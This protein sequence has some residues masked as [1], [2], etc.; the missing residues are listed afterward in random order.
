MDIQISSNFERL[1]FELGGRD[2]DRVR[3]LMAGLAQ[4]GAFTLAAGEHA[5]LARMFAAHRVGEDEALAAIRR[6]HA[7]TGYVSEPHTIA[8]IEAARRERASGAARGVPVITLATA[9]PAKFPAA[10]RQAL[11]VAP[12]EPSRVAEQRTKPERISVLPND[13]RAIAE[14]VSNRTRATRAAA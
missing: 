6:V 1:L 13:V 4:S 8:G 5:G 14:F 12:A 7:E 2:A 3:V 10:I 9:H 11:G